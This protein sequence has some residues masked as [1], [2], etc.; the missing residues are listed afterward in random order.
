MVGLD[1]VLKEDK[2]DGL[3]RFDP[4]INRVLEEVPGLLHLKK[5]YHAGQT[6]CHLTNNIDIAIKAGSV[7]IGHG[8]NILQRP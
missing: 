1:F 8:I 6:S 5:V 3:E 4:I 2:F 7:R